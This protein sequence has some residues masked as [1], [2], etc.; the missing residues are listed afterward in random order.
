MNVLIACEESQEV[1]KAF[2]AKGHRAFSCDIQEC[3]GGHPEWH[4]YG[5]AIE[6]INLK[7]C[8][9][10]TQ[11]GSTHTHTQWDILIAHPPCT[12]LSNVATRHFSLRCT[13]PDKV[14]KRWEERAKAAVFFMQFILADI[15]RIAVENPV[16]FMNTAYRKPDQTIHP[17]MFA[18]S[19][20][21]KAQ[22]APHIVAHERPTEAKQRRTLWADV[23]RENQNMGRYIFSV[24]KSEKQNISRHSKS[25]GRAMGVRICQK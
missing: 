25:N 17:F 19:V 9:F 6:A 18:D 7:G 8:C 24:C 16:G 22:Y 11:D 20:E 13:P 21:D 2:R 23:K 5:D 3:S 1:C 10:L 12:Y 14:I 4:I 15:P